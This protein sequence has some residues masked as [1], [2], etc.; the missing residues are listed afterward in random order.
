MKDNL[1]QQELPGIPR[2]DAARKLTLRREIEQYEAV[3]AEHGALVAPL[4]A[5]RLLGLSRQRIH[6][7]SQAGM[8]DSYRYFGHVFVALRD[9]ERLQFMHRPHGVNRK[10]LDKAS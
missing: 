8:L 10:V 1:E 9:V 6:Q 3:V 7:L 4:I 2:G 5:A